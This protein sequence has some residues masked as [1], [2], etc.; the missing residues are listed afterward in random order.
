VVSRTQPP[1][2]GRWSRARRVPHLRFD[3]CATAPETWP[4]PAILHAHPPATSTD[5]PVASDGEG[6]GRHSDSQARRAQANQPLHFPCHAP[7]VAP[8]PRPFCDVSGTPPPAMSIDRWGPGIGREQRWGPAGNRPLPLP[9]RPHWRSNSDHA[10]YLGRN[11]ES[12]RDPG[13]ATVDLGINILSKQTLNLSYK[14]QVRQCSN[15]QYKI[16]SNA[17]YQTT[18]NA[19]NFTADCILW[20][21]MEHLLANT[22]AGSQ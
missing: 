16:Q 9:W 19:D 13:I 11:R 1:G 17:S 3:R 21:K 22:E 2:A 6:E 10:G 8:I 15:S 14:F 5:C 12:H 7:T 4:L 18:T 20:N